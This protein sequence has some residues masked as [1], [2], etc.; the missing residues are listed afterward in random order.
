M[1]QVEKCDRRASNRTNTPRE[2]VFRSVIAGG[3]TI[4]VCI[5]PGKSALTP[6]LLFNGIGA[7]LELVFPFIQ[8]L[9]PDLEVIAFDVPGVGYS[10]TP[11]LPYMF[12]TLA[13]TV[14]KMLDF[15]GYEKVSVAGVSWG[16]FLAQ[17]FA[18]D[19][20][21]RCDKLILAATSAGVLSVMPSPHVLALMASP[22]R[23]TDPAYMAQ[24]A[25]EIYGGAFR[26][27]KEL[28]QAHASK[29][30]S[31]GGRGYYYQMFAVYF[32]S[33]LFWLYKI[34][35]PTLVMAGNDDPLIPLVNMRT[36]AWLI[37]KAK[38]HVVDDGHLFLVTQP[39]AIA[40]VVMSFLSGGNNGS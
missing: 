18:C 1:S 25:P 9:D 17:Q 4:R 35:Q 15:L 33:S 6:L 7:S 2:F 11:L 26:H 28:A 37:P 27:D 32:W 39:E 19:H 34:K 21:E 20:P 10:T 5:R 29:M 40:P 13:N 31:S 12:S 8:A 14:A 23:Y 22:R 16:G 30:Q 3:Q 36:L 24:I 38:L